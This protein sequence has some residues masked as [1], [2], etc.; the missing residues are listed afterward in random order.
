M[1][2]CCINKGFVQALSPLC[3]YMAYWESRNIINRALLI[4]LGVNTFPWEGDTVLT[5]VWLWR[6]QKE[7]HSFVWLAL[8]L[9]SCRKLYWFHWGCRIIMKALAGTCNGYLSILQTTSANLRMFN[10]SWESQGRKEVLGICT[11]SWQ[12][13]AGRPWSCTQ[14]GVCGE[15][16]QVKGGELRGTTRAGNY[17]QNRGHWRKPGKDQR[18]RGHGQWQQDVIFFLGF[19]VHGSKPTLSEK[20]PDDGSRS[21]IPFASIPGLTHV[22]TYMCEFYN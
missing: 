14:E 4:T 13:G 22:H 17:L 6:H 19:G 20:I 18:G 12:P 1:Y 16:G 8:S 11:A 10:R 5:S 3:A 2:F 15:Q 9:E 7:E 21:A